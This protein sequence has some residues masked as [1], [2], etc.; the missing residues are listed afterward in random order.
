MPQY[1][2]LF[3]ESASS[4]A[5]QVDT[6][7]FFLVVLSA[8][9]VILIFGLVA[10]FAIRYRRRYEGQKAVQIHGSTALE[11]AWTVIPFL[12][13]LVL[14][15]WGAGLYYRNARAPRN[16]IEIYVVG[17][18]WMWKLQHPEGPREINELH[19]P[20]GVP[21]RMIMTSEDVIHGFYIPAFRIKQ[22]VLPGRYT[23]EW[24][25]ATRPGEYH[26]FC[27][28]YCGTE[29]SGM[30][31]TVHVMEPSQYQSWLTSRPGGESMAVA[32]K[33]LFDRL[34][35]SGCHRERGTSRG[36]AL[37]GVF[38]QEVVLEGG[39]RALAD[40]GYLRESILNPRA[41]VVMGYQPVM[42]TYQGQLKEDQLLQLIAYIKSLRQ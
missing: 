39:Q 19:I 3:P 31:G 5:G 37:A 4:A 24:F 40:E 13:T 25:R 20:A 22:D 27:S 6:L 8:F 2:P 23:S 14:F 32:G 18:Q 10:L 12:L 17:K 9:F 41:K 42:P 1:F 26:L 29:H 21:V 38:G 36:P 15:G 7:Y 33:Q 34:G 11:V 16:A 28:Q 35:C 30:I